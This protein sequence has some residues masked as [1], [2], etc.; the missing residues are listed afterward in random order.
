MSDSGMSVVMLD[1]AFA[2][3]APK[4]NFDCPGSSAPNPTASPFI[5]LSI[6]APPLPDPPPSPVRREGHARMGGARKRTRASFTRSRVSMASLPARVKSRTKVPLALLVTTWSDTV[7]AEALLE[8]GFLV[9]S[10]GTTHQ[11]P[12]PSCGS[13]ENPADPTA[14]RP[15]SCPSLLIRSH[16]S[17]STSFSDMQ[18]SKFV[19]T[20]SLPFGFF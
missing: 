5:D 4:V 8:S 9:S 1:H 11:P 14:M 17:T 6:S 12:L 18:D 16:P 2:L 20:L 3:R 10:P 19:G 13:K 15:G 7:W